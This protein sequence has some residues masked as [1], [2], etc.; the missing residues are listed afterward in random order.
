MMAGFSY[1]SYLFVSQS[2]IAVRLKFQDG[3]ALA[4]PEIT[5]WPP[6]FH[7]KDECCDFNEY[8]LL[9]EYSIKSILN[10]IFDGPLFP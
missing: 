8:N 1:Q 6:S 7:K 3:K 9:T 2:K 10:Q 5:S 4:V